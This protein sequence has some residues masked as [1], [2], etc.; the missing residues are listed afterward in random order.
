MPSID[1]TAF[2]EIVVVFLIAAAITGSFYFGRSLKTQTMPAEAKQRAIKALDANGDGQYN[3]AEAYTV[4][5][6]FE[7][8]FTKTSEDP[9]WLRFEKYDFDQSGQVDFGDLAFFN[10]ALQYL[11]LKLRP[12]ASPPP[13]ES[14]QP[15]I[16][17][18]YFTEYKELNLDPG[19]PVRIAINWEDFE[20]RDGKYDWNPNTNKQARILKEL[21]DDNKNIIPTIRSKS[22]WASES[23]KK[24]KCASPPKDLQ[25]KFNPSYGHSKTYYEFVKKFA[26]Q[27]RGW[28]EIAVIENEMNDYDFW[29]GTAD[30]YRQLLITAKK[31]FNEI[32]PRVKIADGGIQGGA[33]EW[34]V[35]KDYLSRGEQ[36]KAIAFYEK[37]YGQKIDAAS[38]K[39]ELSKKSK[40]QPP[41]MA[42]ELLD[43][44][45]Y[46]LADIA[47]FHH[48]QYAESVP[49]VIAFL[50]RIAGGKPIMTNEIGSKP[51]DGQT[52]TSAAEMIKKI[53]YF[54]YL[55]VK[56]TLWF[57]LSGEDD[58]HIGLLFDGDKIVKENVDA[59]STALK[60]LNRNN[61]TKADL[62]SGKI[63][64]F[65][66]ASAENEVHVL[67]SSEE[68]EYAVAP[69]CSA[70]D[71]RG[72]AIASAVQLD[73]K[74]VFMVCP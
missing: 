62:S 48:Y 38:L 16:G 12:D 54:S 30:E 25:A 1:K 9:D 65:S 56:P 43:G 27:Y 7:Q 19:V 36:E 39:K 70:Y 18:F 15:P 49:E 45:L 40:K 17:I 58:R 73:E 67:W 47:N 23:V 13:A 55:N 72:Q 37:A 44:D 71:Y 69:G 74:P 32:D 41:K 35:I 59:F 8:A 22:S 3:E 50:R 31:A 51:D 14:F 4:Y 61:T 20:I 10:M 29:C 28:F 2:R 68:T 53:A 57:S 46:A 6:G 34:A 64:E 24:R 33:L 5:L 63:K 52:A 66:F 60:Y 21:K 11:D 26:E 42:F